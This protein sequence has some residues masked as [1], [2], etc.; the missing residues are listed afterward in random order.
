MLK[1]KK[2]YW[3]MEQC[4]AKADFPGQKIHCRMPDLFS[5]DQLFNPL[6]RLI[7]CCSPPRQVWAVLM[8]KIFI[9]DFLIPLKSPFKLII[10]PDFVIFFNHRRDVFGFDNKLMGIFHI[11][12]MLFNGGFGFGKFYHIG[13]L[14]HGF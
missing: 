6:Y 7:N 8:C 13:G 5:V 10:F 14:Q 12:G 3:F 1:E 2:G 11:A 4:L 9:P